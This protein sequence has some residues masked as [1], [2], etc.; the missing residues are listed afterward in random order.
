MSFTP[1]ILAF[2]GSARRASYNKRLVRIA[3]EAAR[4]AGA[5]VT[6]IELNEYPLPLFNEDEEAEQ[7]LP[8]NGR[9]IK[10][11]DALASRFFDLVP[12]IQQLDQR[13]FEEHAGLGFATRERSATLGLL[14]R[15]G[16]RAV[17]RLAR[18]V[19][20]IAGLVHL[21]AILGN[22][23][24]LILPGTLSIS[25]AMDAFAEDGSLKD[26]KKQAAVEK[27]GANLAAFLRKLHG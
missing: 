10:D 12:G 17:E 14:Y 26:A 15:Q 22:L 23:G 13:M 8:A 19:G 27:L 1:K 7:G 21:R 24:T 16:G 11:F 20:R 2:A 5:E 6:V 9:K 18:R 4:A 3:A 25:Q